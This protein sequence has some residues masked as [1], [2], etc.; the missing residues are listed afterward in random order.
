M[1]SLC[2]ASVLAACSLAGLS[3]AMAAVPA[4][5]R[6]EAQLCVTLSA[7]DASCGPVELEWQRNGMARLR[8]DD[9]RYELQLHSSQVEVVLTHGTMR[10]DEFVAPYEWVG[11][12]LQFVDV[13]KNVRYELLPGERRAARH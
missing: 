8:V 9:I 3:A 6:Y 7:T 11:N 5:G 1:R 2:F 10:I 12:S 4:V 13:A